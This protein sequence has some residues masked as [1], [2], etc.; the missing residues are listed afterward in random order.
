MRRV[1]ALVSGMGHHVEDL[2]RAA[3][4]MGVEFRAIG[5]PSLSGRFGLSGPAVSAEGVDLTG[6]DGV[7]IRMMPPGSLEQ[8]VFRMDALHRLEALGVP[9]INPPRAVE[10]A[11]DKYLT[12]ARLAGAG[13]PV[14]RT[15]A[16]E[17]VDEALAMFDALGRDVVVKPIFGSEGRGLTRLQDRELAWRVFHAIIR[18]GS[19]IYLQEFLAHPGYD[20][21]VLVLGDRVLGAIRRWSSGN[22]WRTNV[23]IGGRAE[24]IEPSAEMIRLSRNAARAVGAVVAGVD[25]LPKTADGE[26]TILEVNA[27]PGWRAFAQATGID[28][29]AALLTEL[30]DPRR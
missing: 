20:Y 30:L 1:V 6:V 8:V 14:P 7:L 12:F 2:K 16:G 3:D 17:S 13:L 11:V 23:A 24:A 4:G 10:T 26:L 21:R 25:L 28:V 29:A 27:V 5:F 19:V 22:D 15:W 18:H 9:L